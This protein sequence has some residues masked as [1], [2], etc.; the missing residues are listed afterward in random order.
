M[1]RKPV[2]AQRKSLTALGTQTSQRG[3]RQMT[4]PSRKVS[5]QCIVGRRDVEEK[6]EEFRRDKLKGD[7][8]WARREI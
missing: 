4:L 8:I 1:S 2:L 3:R 6:Q 5:V 7:W